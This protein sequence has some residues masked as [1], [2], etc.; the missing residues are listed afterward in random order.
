MKQTEIS[1]LTSSVTFPLWASGRCCTAAAVSRRLTCVTL[2]G[3]STGE[4]DDGVRGAQGRRRRHAVQR[5]GLRVHPEPAV[6]LQRR[7]AASPLTSDLGRFPGH[8]SFTGSD[9]LSLMKV[10]RV[11]QEVGGSGLERSE[12]ADVC[13]VWMNH[14]ALVWLQDTTTSPTASTSSSAWAATGLCST[15][16]PSSR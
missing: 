6:H 8:D 4:A 5:R 11:K 14:S 1:I 16:R 2:A 3:V 13:D 10:I 7:S 15:P 12:P 9:S